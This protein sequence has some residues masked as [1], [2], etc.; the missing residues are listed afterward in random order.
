MITR[1]LY[2]A[3]IR[4]IVC[5]ESVRRRAATGFAEKTKL[6]LQLLATCTLPKCV[7]R[8]SVSEKK[9]RAKTCQTLEGLGF[10][11]TKRPKVS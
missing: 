8:S 5:A 6:K 1:T 2:L 3:L 4:Y 7:G 9:T 10:L 11:S